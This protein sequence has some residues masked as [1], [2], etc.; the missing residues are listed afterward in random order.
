MGLRRHPRRRV[1]VRN[2]CGMG[3]RA[4][5]VADFLGCV[6]QLLFVVVETSWQLG[7]P[8]W[9]FLDARTARWV[10]I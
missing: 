9:Q 6:Q 8:P 2:G 7:E 3:Y 4:S 5:Y 1:D 10:A